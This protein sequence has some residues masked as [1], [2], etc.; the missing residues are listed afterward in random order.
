M[1]IERLVTKGKSENKPKYNL[2]TTE[3]GMPLYY[4]TTEKNT[5]ILNLPT[6]H[7][8]IRGDQNVCIQIVYLQQLKLTG[9]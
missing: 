8:A 4:R 9:K 2:K 3:L 6:P 1:A 5:I 7:L